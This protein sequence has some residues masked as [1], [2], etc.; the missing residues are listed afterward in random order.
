VFSFA[1]KYF[2]K[3][4]SIYYKILTRTPCPIECFINEYNTNFTQQ[5]F[6]FIKKTR[7]CIAYLAKVPEDHIYPQDKFD[8]T[9]NYLS[10]WSSI[11][12]STF[13]I[14]LSSETNIVFSPESL[15]NVTNPDISP[16]ISVK[17][18]ICE[19]LL[20]AKI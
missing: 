14:L 19:L 10:F 6:D 15:Q 13:I 4:R 5:Q 11:D 7:S 8:D 9:I 16:D 12:E 20:A 2:Y 18:F 17:D 1:N 3:K